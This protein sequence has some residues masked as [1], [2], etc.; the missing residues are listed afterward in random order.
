MLVSGY[1]LTERRFLRPRI[2]TSSKVVSSTCFSDP[3]V[4]RQILRVRKHDAMTTK[5]HVP[6][7]LPFWTQDLRDPFEVTRNFIR[8]FDKEPWNSPGRRI[9]NLLPY[10]L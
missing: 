10:L 6:T 5:L 8:Y 4:E 7:L 2:F 9:E 3:L 1:L